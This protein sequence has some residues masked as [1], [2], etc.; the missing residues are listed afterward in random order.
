L[1]GDCTLIGNF[2]A[3]DFIHAVENVPNSTPIFARSAG[4]YCQILQH[5][6]KEYAKIRLPSGSQRLIPVT[7]K[8]TL[9]VIANEEHNLKVLEKAGRSR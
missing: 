4:T 6:S 3:G 5:D 7:A 8:A 2:E 1:P 9:G